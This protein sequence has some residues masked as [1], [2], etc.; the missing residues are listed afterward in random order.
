MCGC[1]FTV[2]VAAVAKY[3]FIYLFLEALEHICISCIYLYCLYFMI[4]TCGFVRNKVQNKSIYQ[5]QN[6]RSYFWVP[7]SSSSSFKSN[8]RYDG[9]AGGGRPTVL[10][11]VSFIMKSL[12]R[13]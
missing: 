8:S 9:G 12:L 1:L 7:A 11:S 13:I 3:L 4:W 10:Y 2:D 6:F 5:Q